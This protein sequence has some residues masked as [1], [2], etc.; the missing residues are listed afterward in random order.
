M[1]APTPEGLK[2]GRE[3]DAL[4]AE[5]V[6]GWRKALDAPVDAHLRWPEPIQAGWLWY[7]P[8]RSP[9]PFEYTIPNYSTDIKDAWQVVE[10]LTAWDARQVPLYWFKL[11]YDNNECWDVGFC[12]VEG[13]EDYSLD[14]WHW[15]TV[16]HFSEVPLAICLA[17]LKAVQP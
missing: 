5:K 14:G 12:R 6:M 11:N 4:I 17:A 15:H 13:H 8:D 7:N 3:L 16:Q 1:S 10:K 2:A 9:C